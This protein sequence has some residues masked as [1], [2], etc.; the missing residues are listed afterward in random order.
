[1]SERQAETNYQGFPLPLNDTTDEIFGMQI[2][3]FKR[4]L[5]V[6]SCGFKKTA[7]CILKNPFEGLF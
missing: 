7:K 5:C 4:G 1:M 6:F 3:P 2:S